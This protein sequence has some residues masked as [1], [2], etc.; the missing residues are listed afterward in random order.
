[1]YAI[2]EK[3]KKKEII[4][5]ILANTSDTL[6]YSTNTVYYKV[7]NSNSKAINILF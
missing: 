3:N 2:C 1:M 5:P 7:P 6:G 4:D